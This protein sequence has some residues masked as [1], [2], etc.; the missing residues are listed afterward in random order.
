MRRIFV[1]TWLLLIALT[2][3]GDGC[4]TTPQPVTVQPE[5][6]AAADVQA[7]VALERFLVAEKAQDFGAAYQALSAP[8]RARYTTERLEADYRRDVDL[9]QDKL[10]RVR[11]ALRG[12]TGIQLDGADAAHLPI[13]GDRQVHLVREPDGWHVASLE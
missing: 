3:L 12:G 5:P 4:V 2:A 11:A 1:G 6:A 9:A 13:A 10:A 8:L 7:R